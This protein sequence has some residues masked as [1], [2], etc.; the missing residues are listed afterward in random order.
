MEKSRERKKVGRMVLTRAKFS[1]GSCCSESTKEL[2]RVPSPT[3]WGKLM[4]QCTMSSTGDG[5]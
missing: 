4:L 2:G 1:P 3:S 5:E